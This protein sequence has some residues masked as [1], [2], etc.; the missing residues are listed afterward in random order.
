MA[1]SH[2]V[3]GEILVNKE[4]CSPR[5]FLSYMAYTDFLGNIQVHP[6]CGRMNELMK[7]TM[8]AT[9]CVLL[10][11]KRILKHSLKHKKII[12]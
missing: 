1:N 4:C 7:F 12:G 3:H 11:T 5:V 10:I 8:K 2:S 6:F 9:K